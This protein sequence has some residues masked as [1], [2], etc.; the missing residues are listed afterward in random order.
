M[1]DDETEGPYEQLLARATADFLEIGLD[2]DE[3]AQLTDALG[4]MLD[5]ALE[6]L[7]VPEDDEKTANDLLRNEV[8]DLLHR[9]FVA[10]VTLYQ[11][12]WAPTAEE[13]TVTLTPDQ[14]TNVVRGLFASG[15][16]LRLEVE[17]PH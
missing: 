17:E 15:V 3:R 11:I 7:E 6:N 2:E 1:P 9:S 16:T 10:G 13:I 4:T 8:L 14:A 12:M 5:T